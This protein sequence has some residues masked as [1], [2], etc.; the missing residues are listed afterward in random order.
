MRDILSFHTNVNRFLRREL[1]RPEPKELHHRGS[2][3][4]SAVVCQGIK[5]GLVT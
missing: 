4:S 5:G 1:L 3:I 2:V